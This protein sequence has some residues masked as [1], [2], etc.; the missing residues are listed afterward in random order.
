M[1]IALDRFASEGH[2]AGL[3]RLPRQPGERSTRLQ[4]QCRVCNFELNMT[5]SLMSVCPKCHA[6]TWEWIALRLNVQPSERAG[7]RFR[8]RAPA[9]AGSACGGR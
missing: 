5:H 8:W 9:V 3:N 2:L 6:S 4:I 7:H 1:P